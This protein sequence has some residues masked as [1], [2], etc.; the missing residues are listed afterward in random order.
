MTQL[1]TF[2]RMDTFKTCRRRHEFLYE[3]GIR[4][5]EEAKALRMG[6]AYHS[7]LE[8]LAKTY[9]I[10]DACDSVYAAYSNVEPFDQHEMEIERETVLRM[11]CG[12]VWRWDGCGLTFVAAEQE[13]ELS[14]VNPD[15]GR[16]TP[17]WNL[18]GKID[19]IVRLED[20]RLAVLETKLL[21]EDISPDSQ[22]WRRMRVDHQISLYVL[23]ARRLGFA[24][25][26]VLYN[27]ACKPSIR[28]TNVAILD[29]L[30]AKIV[31]DSRGE[32]VRTEK[33]LWRQTGDSAKGYT[34]QTRPMQYS[35]WGVKLADDI[36]AQPDRYFARVEIPR[37]DDDL[38]MFESEIWQIQKSMR[39]AQLND[40][41]F[42][43]C[44][45]HTCSYCSVFD[46]CTTGW[47]P[48]DSLPE[49]YVR[50]ENVNPEL[51]RNANV[52]RIAAEESATTQSEP[53]AS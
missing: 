2:S 29:D 22:L 18:A 32:R 11:V 31:L 46:L 28:P 20:G 6:S 40:R 38:K 5:T 19:G 33:G 34:L 15:T 36:A 45:F 16:T 43:T 35:E 30:G 4:R 3:L 9:D 23:A 48:T 41:H 50:L 12:Y 53:T 51:Q 1:L 52:N 13:F 24:C 10:H 47:Q 7:A 17:N 42:R 49:G 21:S 8:S 25:D 37:L 14:L 39:D 44:N 27:P 26:C